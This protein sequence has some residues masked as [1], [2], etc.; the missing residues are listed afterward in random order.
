MQFNVDMAF[1]E[2]VKIY[3]EAEDIVRKYSATTI[4]E[5]EYINGRA[6]HMEKN[7]RTRFVMYL[8]S[9]EY[10]TIAHE[11]SHIADYACTFFDIK[12]DEFRAYMVGHLV[13]Q[14]IHKLR[15][16]NGAHDDDAHRRAK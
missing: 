6:L 9:T 12:D 13:D 11:S 2:K 3:T 8:G 15:R 10:K 1:G 7:G 4:S 14:I 5:F 16:K